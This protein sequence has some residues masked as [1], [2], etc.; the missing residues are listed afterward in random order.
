LV[1]VGGLGTA[2]AALQIRLAGADEYLEQ[3]DLEAELG[4]VIVGLVD[5][6]GPAR[7]GRVLV[8]LS[9][10]GGGGASTIAANLAVSLAVEAKAGVA[11]VD[12][13]PATGTLAEFLGLK[14]VHTHLDLTRSSERMDRDALERALVQHETGVRL[15]ASPRQY[16]AHQHLMPE[17]VERLVELTRTRFPYVVLDLDGQLGPPMVR[18]ALLA[19]AVVV[20]FRQEF[21]SLRVTRLAVDHL[22][23]QG[24][25]LSRLCLVGTRRGQPREVPVGKVEEALGLKLIAGIP[26]DY[27]AVIRAANNGVPLVVE[28]RS[29]RAAKA[30]G[31]LARVLRARVESTSW[32]SGARA[33]PGP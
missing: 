4:A 8:V 32:A 3:D 30:I 27:K 22:Q 2:R 13:V 15:L 33:D 19:D 23:R 1:V 14:P 20:V 21:T 16:D 24:V 31:D 18:A 17:F 25:M 9:P 5:R 6:G 11:L 12:L 7:S 28:G 29:S 10:S 26:D